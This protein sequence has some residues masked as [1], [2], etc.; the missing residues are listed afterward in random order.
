MKIG[1]D[2]R[3]LAVTTTERGKHVAKRESDPLLRTEEAAEQLGVDP[4]TLV[5]WRYLGK[6]PDYIKVGRKYVRYRQS[7]IDAWI[8]LHTV[9]VQDTPAA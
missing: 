2:N 7:A 4:E 9:Q 1:E 3:R 6:G 8:D 5:Q